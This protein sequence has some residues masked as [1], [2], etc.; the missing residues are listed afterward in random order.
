MLNFLQAVRKVLMW[1]EV[2]P[3]VYDRIRDGYEC[4]VRNYRYNVVWKVTQNRHRFNVL[5]SGICLTIAE[6]KSKALSAVKSSKKR[7]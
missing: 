6:A 1:V 4:R 7:I 5:D 3:G 2:Q